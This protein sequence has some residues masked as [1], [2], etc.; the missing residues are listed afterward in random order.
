VTADCNDPMSTRTQR[1][2]QS[3]TDESSGAGNEDDHECGT[4]N[5]LAMFNCQCLARFLIVPGFV[6]L[7]SG[8][9]RPLPS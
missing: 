3:A 8:A 1:S 4:R 9:N 2:G 5:V 7:R 6:G